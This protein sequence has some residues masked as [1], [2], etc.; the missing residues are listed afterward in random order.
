MFN[1]YAY[2]VGAKHLLTEAEQAQEDAKQ[3]VSQAAN[4]PEGQEAMMKIMQQI[5]QLLQTKYQKELAA[6][7]QKDGGNVGAA[8]DALLKQ[9]EAEIVAQ[10]KNQVK[11]Q[12]NESLNLEEGFLDRQVNKVKGMY[13]KGKDVMSGNPT[14]NKSWKDEAILKRFESLKQSLSKELAELKAD[15]GTTS[16][17][18]KMLLHKLLQITALVLK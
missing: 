7:Q 14:N 10:A 17:T 2:S 8:V 1:A 16:D 5:Q 18:D 6:A 9:I 13:Q 11:T 15:L 12:K 4:S 3:K